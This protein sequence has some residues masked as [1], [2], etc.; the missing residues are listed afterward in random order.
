LGSIRFKREE[1][2]HPMKELSGGQKAKVFLTQMMLDSANVL[3]LDEPTRNFSPLSQPR[4][5]SVLREYTGSI[6]S[7]SHD[8]KYLYEVCDKVYS[9]TGSGL[10]LVDKECVL[11]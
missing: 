6:I 9:L 8:R 3:I 7:V 10:T 5:R 11:R 2:F 1:M 4:I